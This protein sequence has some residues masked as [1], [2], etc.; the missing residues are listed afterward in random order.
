M[1]DPYKAANAHDYPLLLKNLLYAPLAHYPGQEIVYAD[2]GRYTYADFRHR[3]ARLANALWELGVT[4]G[5]TVAV[6][7][8]SRR[9]ACSG[10]NG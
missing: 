7:A 2:Y 6:M 9:P 3:I 1:H 10:R 8:G 4:H 5:S